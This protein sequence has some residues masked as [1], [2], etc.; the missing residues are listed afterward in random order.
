M[1]VPTKTPTKTIGTFT[2]TFIPAVFAVIGDAF[3]EKSLCVR[4]KNSFSE[5][6]L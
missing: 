4:K 1:K 3:S 6:G 2:G 5:N